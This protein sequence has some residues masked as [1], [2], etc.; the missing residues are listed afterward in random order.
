[1]GRPKV[2]G[3]PFSYQF[4]DSSIKGT[5]YT[6]ELRGASKAQLIRFSNWLNT[7]PK[8]H[9]LA[10]IP[11]FNSY[12]PIKSKRNVKGNWFIDSV[13]TDPVR[14]VDMM[15]QA[16]KVANE[17]QKSGEN[18]SLQNQSKESII[19]QSTTAKLAIEES[20]TKNNY[21]IIGSIGVVVLVAIIILIKK[22]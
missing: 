11:Q 12:S 2:N 19:A 20:Q 22:L 14:V 1:M 6:N 4:S 13:S 17:L 21:L 10:W 15:T 16:E 7:I 5:D 9:A 3:K 8:T 18:V